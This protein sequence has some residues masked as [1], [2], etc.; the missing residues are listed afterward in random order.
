MRPDHHIA[1]DS[2]RIARS[3]RKDQNSEQIEP[4]LDSSDCAAQSENERAAEIECDEQR[5][6]DDLFVDDQLAFGDNQA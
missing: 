1:G 4:V 5:I 6:H 2:T 3:E